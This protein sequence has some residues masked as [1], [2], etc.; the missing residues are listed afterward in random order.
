MKLDWFFNWWNAVYAVPL[1]FVLIFL[2][3]TSLVSLVGGAFGEW[4]CRLGGKLLRGQLCAMFIHGVHPSWGVSREPTITVWSRTAGRVGSRSRAV[5]RVVS[6]PRLMTVTCRG[7]SWA[8][9]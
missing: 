6:G 7:C 3:V 9:R 1:A 8:G 4:L 5:A 2:T